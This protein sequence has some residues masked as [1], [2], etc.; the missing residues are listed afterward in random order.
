MKIYLDDL[1]PIPDGYVGV[2]TSDE[3]QALIRKIVAEGTPVE[4]ISFDH[5]LGETEMSGSQLTRWLQD[6][7]PQIFKLCAEMR[8]HSS[9]PVGRDDMQRD[10]D[11]G[12]KYADELIAALDLPDPWAERE[13]DEPTQIQDPETAL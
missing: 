7:A 12:Y 1:R 5:D 11:S 6:T 3:F 8:I 2:R 13:E 9:N 10:I 4:E